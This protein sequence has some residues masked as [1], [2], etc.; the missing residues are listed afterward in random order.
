MV[1]DVYNVIKAYRVSLQNLMQRDGICQKNKELIAAWLA[2]KEQEFIAV[3]GN[4]TT[5]QI[6]YLKTL[7]KYLF[8]LNNLAQWFKKPFNEITEQ[9]IRRVYEELESGE[10]G[11]RNGKPFTKQTR[12]D[13]YNKVF[14]SDFFK[15]IGKYELAQHVVLRRMES[16]DAVRFFTIEDLERMTSMTSNP[17]SK[18]ILNLLF[19]TGMRI[20]TLLNI[21]KSDIEKIQREIGH[22]TKSYYIIHIKKE[23]T[24][25][26]RDS[27]LSILLDNTNELL[28]IQ[29]PKMHDDDYVV[30]VSYSSV[31][32]LVKRYSKKANVSTKPDNKPISIHDF[33]RSC[34]CYL[35]KQGLSIDQ[36]K[37]RLGH[38]PSSTVI[39]KYVDYLALDDNDGVQLHEEKSML[40][41]KKEH[42]K[43]QEHVNI[44]TENNKVL[45]TEISKL[46]KEYLDMAS[47]IRAE[48]KDLI[49]SEQEKNK[50]EERLIWKSKART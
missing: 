38:K 50:Q 4:E 13:Y 40:D 9:D 1:R 11:R 15:F 19:D 41:M 7:S 44:L 25:S 36:I 17:Q 2:K 45:V 14:K 23:Y 5:S 39:D 20:G 35:L 3:K 26:N 32:K 22:G 49:A 42:E 10:I 27:T 24:K 8:M 28:D 21:R 46:R 34:G 18:L 33:R 6:R 37:K 12:K 48:V 29:L 47:S 43:T 30:D 16:E 31:V